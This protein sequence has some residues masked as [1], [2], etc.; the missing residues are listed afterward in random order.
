MSKKSYFVLAVVALLAAGFCYGM[1]S[2]YA[3][4]GEVLSQ[5]AAR[6]DEL[7]AQTNAASKRAETAYGQVKE[8]EGKLS[9]ISDEAE[10]LNANIMQLEDDLAARN[11]GRTVCRRSVGNEPQHSCQPRSASELKNAISHASAVLA[12]KQKE[13]QQLSEQR[14]RNGMVAH[15]ASQARLSYQALAE[16]ILSRQQWYGRLPQGDQ[17]TPED[18]AVALKKAS[19]MDHSTASIFGNIGKGGL[20]VGIAMA[21]LGVLAGRRRKP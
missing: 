6:L 14:E 1:R 13:A 11:G 19:E 10:E 8:L 5:M 2:S 20:I 7:G 16:V 3:N 12:K 9:V 4:E 21:F 18:G 17:L 15:T